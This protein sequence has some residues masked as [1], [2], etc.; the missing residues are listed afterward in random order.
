[1]YQSSAPQADADTVF[2]ASRLPSAITKYEQSASSI[3]GQNG[4]YF[5]NCKFGMHGPLEVFSQ[6]AVLTLQGLFGTC[7]DYF[8][9]LCSGDCNWG[10][11]LWVDQCLKRRGNATIDR[12]NNYQLLEEE[13]CDPKEGWEDCS[14]PEKV[15]FHPFK[16]Q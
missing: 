8:M 3:D 9:D 15:A 5:N 2:I 16:S 13:H 10:E 4:V 7:Y 11:D 6:K 1:M 14:D 12:V